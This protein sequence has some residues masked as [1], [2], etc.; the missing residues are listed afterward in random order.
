ML[1]GTDESRLHP[2]KTLVSIIRR[3]LSA[4]Y[5]LELKFQDGTIQHADVLIGDDGPFGQMRSE[6]LGAKHP[7]NPPVFMN[8]LSAV[9]HVE[10]N[11]AEKL[12][13][14]K[15]GNRDLGRR[16]ER[17]G[18]GSWFLNA[19]LEGFSTCL[20]SFYTEESYD[21]SQFTRATSV[22][23]LTARFGNL[24]RGEGI[25]GVSPHHPSSYHPIP[26]LI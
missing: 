17:V 5:P 18:T 13:G 7:A 24:K 1:N 22:H 20:G 4:K 10:P 21:L 9:A 26:T 25:T 15:Y 11:A 6:V 14:Q 12:L 19:Y 16:F 23:E 2:N 3:D 8:F